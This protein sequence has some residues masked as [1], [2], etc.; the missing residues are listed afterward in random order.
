MAILKTDWQS[1]LSQDSELPPDVFFLVKTNDGLIVEDFGE[2]IGAHKFLLAGISPVFR[3]M[4]F[5]PMKETGEVVKVEETTCE[6]FN[7]MISFIY[8]PPGDEFTLND[9]RCP[10][11]LF[12]LLALSDK[13]EILS[14]KALT[15]NALETLPIS[16]ENM[17]FVATVAKSYKLLFEDVSTKLLMRCLEFINTSDGRDTLA[18][19]LET[20][21]KFPEASF[22]VLHE[23]MNVGD[24]TFQMP[25]ISNL[26]TICF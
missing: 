7:T 4:F 23:L 8:Q 26:C 12:E 6:A 5:G 20:R 13:Y 11:K 16:N 10:Q 14:L 9:I 17:I 1:F 15:S 3:R 21:N 2:A 25:G 18:L 19:I 22:D 24:A